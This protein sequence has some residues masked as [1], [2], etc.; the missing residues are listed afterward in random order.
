VLGNSGI[1]PECYASLGGTDWAAK[2]QRRIRDLRGC[3]V[4]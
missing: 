2:R 4:Q 3:E 1:S